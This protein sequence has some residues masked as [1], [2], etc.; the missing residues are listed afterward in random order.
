MFATSKDGT[1]QCLKGAMIQ[2]RCS[3]LEGT[4]N[5]GKTDVGKRR[6]AAPGEIALRGGRLGH[7]GV[8][9]CA[10]LSTGTFTFVRRHTR[11]L[12]AR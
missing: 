11:K 6:R 10:Y 9:R 2:L 1:E 4:E 5:L 3:I 7:T 8:S 12:Q